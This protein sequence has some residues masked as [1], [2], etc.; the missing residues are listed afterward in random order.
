MIHQFQFFQMISF[1]PFPHVRIFC[2]LNDWSSGHFILDNAVL[3]GSAQQKTFY[4]EANDSYFFSK[5]I[6]SK[7]RLL[8]VFACSIMFDYVD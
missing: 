5:E 3:V 4:L 6:A 2:N 7:F 8:I 1:L